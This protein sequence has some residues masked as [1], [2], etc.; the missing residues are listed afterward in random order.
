MVIVCRK[1]DKEP[2]QGIWS[3]LED[4]IYLEA[5]EEIRKIQNSGRELSQGDVFVIAIGKCLE[6]YSKHYPNV[7]RDGEK[8][9]VKE[10]LDFIQEI[11][12]GQLMGGLFDDLAEETDLP[13]ATYLTYIAGK[14][15]EISYSSLNKNLQQRNIDISD[16]V[17]KG[18]IE[19][20]G[21]K[22]VTPDLES[23]AHEIEEMKEDEL[24]AID[25]AHYL[26]YLKDQDQL[27]SK[28]H[29]WADEASVAALEK[30]AEKENSEDYR[31]LS[32]YVKEKTKDQTLRG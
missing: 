23:R 12:D 3:E 9:P 32:E 28:M 7:V 14:G 21:S 6:L 17:D 24:T 22:I 18:I 2:E 29:Q 5:K 30:L 8:I 13:T 11:V 1:R 10:A 4:Q 26:I 20:D 27:A 31:E 15:G 25:K 19:K 16:L